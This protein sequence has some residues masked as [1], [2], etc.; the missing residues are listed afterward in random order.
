[1]GNYGG[2]VTDDKDRRWILNVLDDF[3]TSQI[4]DDDYK[5]SPSGTYYA[6]PN[7][8]LDNFVDYVRTLP[9]NE[10]PEVFGLHDNA[11]I[12][13]AI[14][15]TNGLLNTALSLQPKSSGGGG[16]SWAET[17]AELAHDIEARI[18]LIFDI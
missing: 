4:L 3:Y 7:G 16:K 12:S 8:T 6:P 15:E 2:R 5:F 14:A 11:N 13:C 18:P 17:L 10:G 1:M 9:Y